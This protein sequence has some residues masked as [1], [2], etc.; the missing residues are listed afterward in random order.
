V[1]AHLWAPVA[2]ALLVVPLE[3]YSSLQGQALQQHQAPGIAQMLPVLAQMQD[4][5]DRVMEAAAG[6]VATALQVRAGHSVLFE[7]GLLG[8]LDQDKGWQSQP[9]WVLDAASLL[10]SAVEV[11]G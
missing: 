3:Q 6:L 4:L 7:L 10:S 5:Q 8:Q 1:F 9:A 2:A 11:C